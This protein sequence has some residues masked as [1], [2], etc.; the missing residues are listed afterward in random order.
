VVCFVHMF[1]PKLCVHLCSGYVPSVA[2]TSLFSVWLQENTS[3][4]VRSYAHEAPRI[5]WGVTLMKL[6]V[7]HV[8]RRLRQI[9]K[10]AF[11]CLSV[12]LCVRL[13]PV[14]SVFSPSGWSNSTP[15]TRNLMKFDIWGLFETVDEIKVSLKF[16]KNNRYFAWRLTCFYDNILNCFYNEKRFRQSCRENQNKHFMFN[17]F[18]PRIS[19]RLWDNVVKHVGAR[20]ATDDNIRNM[21]HAHCMLDNYGF[22]SNTHSEYL[23]FITYSRQQCASVLHYTS[24]AWASCRLLLLRRKHSPQHPVPSSALNHKYFQWPP[25]LCRS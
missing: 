17:Y 13:S 9:V 7:I 19:C 11:T 18:F 12:R 5:L 6:L 16:D 25:C 21:V 1:P 22:N 2:P 3:H 8:F 20:L 24:I 4:F 15:I 14:L 10:R 23:I